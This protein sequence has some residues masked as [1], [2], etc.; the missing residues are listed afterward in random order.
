MLLEKFSAASAYK[1]EKSRKVGQFIGQQKRPIFW[2]FYVNE[3]QQSGPNQYHVRRMRIVRLFRLAVQSGT[4]LSCIGLWAAEE[5]ERDEN[6]KNVQ[7][8]EH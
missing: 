7:N 8:L 2:C 5:E 4:T 1:R 6:D 3:A